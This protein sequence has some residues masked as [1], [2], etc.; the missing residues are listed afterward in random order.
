MRSSHHTTENFLKTITIDDESCVYV[1]EYRQTPW[2]K[3]KSTNV[4]KQCE[5]IVESFLQ[6]FPEYATPGQRVNKKYYR[7]VSRRLRNAVRR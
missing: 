3:K 4:S 6:L 5:D 1:L 2:D 7:N